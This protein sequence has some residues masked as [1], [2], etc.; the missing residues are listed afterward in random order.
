MINMTLT[1]NALHHKWRYT[2]KFCGIDGREITYENSGTFVNI[3]QERSFQIIRSALLTGEW[4]RSD[5]GYI[6]NYLD[7]NGRR[8]EALL[9]AVNFYEYAIRLNIVRILANRC[10]DAPDLADK[11][12]KKAEIIAKT[13]NMYEVKDWNN[14]KRSLREHK[15]KGRSLE[16]DYM[17]IIGKYKLY[18]FLDFSYEPIP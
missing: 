14:T 10:E 18:T 11:V 6:P 4:P 15:K 13:H 8:S 16:T 5:R 1:P 2:I 12:V 9:D 17:W 7:D 3:C